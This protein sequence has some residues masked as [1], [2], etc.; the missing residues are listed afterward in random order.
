[1]RLVSYDDYKPLM[2]RPNRKGKITGGE[3]FRASLS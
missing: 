1:M 2:I 3:R